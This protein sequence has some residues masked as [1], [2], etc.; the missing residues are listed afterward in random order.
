MYKTPH[1]EGQK[2][3]EASAGSAL[4][5]RALTMTNHS[6]NEHWV[7]KKKDI[8][9]MVENWIENEHGVCHLYPRYCCNRIENEHRVCNL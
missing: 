2:T 4:R 1:P 6:E 3:S 7:C 8:Y 9:E 5:M